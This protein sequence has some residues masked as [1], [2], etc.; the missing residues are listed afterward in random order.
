MLAD[1][2]RLF[3][4]GNISGNKVQLTAADVISF[5]LGLI[6]W[7]GI[8]MGS[9]KSISSVN[10]LIPS[11]GNSSSADSFLGGALVTSTNDLLTFSNAAVSA[12]C[13]GVNG[14]ESRFRSCRVVSFCPI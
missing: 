13:V 5:P 8:F 2:F 3:G 4:I 14:A 10:D 12:L 9:G 1:L 11:S 6:V 7:T